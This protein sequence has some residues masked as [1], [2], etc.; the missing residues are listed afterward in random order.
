MREVDGRAIPAFIK[1]ALNN[2]PIIVFGD[3]RQTR[4]FCYISDL[5]K[6][7]CKLMKS[8]VNTP[9]NMGSPEEMNIVDLANNIIKLTNSKSK[10]VFGPLPV[11]DPKTRQPEIT[12]AKMILDWY[13][14]IKLEDGLKK[15]IQW[16]KEQ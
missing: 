1:G 11:D 8:K 10:I 7:I 2:Q 4:S 6:G 13:P 12:L 9:I 14:K 16:F 15:T 3:G 5:I